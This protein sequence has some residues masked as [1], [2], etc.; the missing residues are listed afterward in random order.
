MTN[1]RCRLGK[2]LWAAA[3]FFSRCYYQEAT[4]KKHPRGTYVCRCFLYLRAKKGGGHCGIAIYVWIIYF[5]IKY[6]IPR[7]SVASSTHSRP[8]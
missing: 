6:R 8:E 7:R 4:I 2:R 1:R 5:C 3:G